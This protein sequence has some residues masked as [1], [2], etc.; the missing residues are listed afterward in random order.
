MKKKIPL[1]P[2]IEE[3]LSLP[4][5]RI[6][7]T[8]KHLVSDI[9]LLTV[10]AVLCCAEDWVNIERFGRA[11]ES[12]FRQFLSL[13]N[14]IPSHDTIG[15]VFSLLDPDAFTRC[16]AS[17]ISKVSELTAGEVVAIDGKTLRRSFDTAAARGPIHMINAWA[18]RTKVS[19]GQR[20]SRGKSNEIETIP[21][22]LDLLD[23]SGC[24]VT[25]DAMGC[26]RKTADKIVEKGA[27]Y[28]P[29]LKGN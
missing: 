27:D 9:V 28:V 19:L 12:F 29:A 3:L 14:G 8:K 10:C 26:Q 17:W 7:R 24:V 21:E 23:I 5:P 13:P 25:I 16:F 18:S 22:L 11:K 20:R 4:D 2:V 6:D 15:R 1:E